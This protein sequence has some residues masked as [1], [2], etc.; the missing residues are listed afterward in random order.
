MQEKKRQ[1]NNQTSSVVQSL[2]CGVEMGK[3]EVLSA[4]CWLRG[5][6]WILT[7]ARVENA[8]GRKSLSY[9]PVISPFFLLWQVHVHVCKCTCVHMHVED[10]GQPQLEFLR[11]ECCPPCLMGQGFSPVWNF[12]SRLGWVANVPP[13]IFLS[14]PFHFGDYK[15]MPPHLAF[16]V[17][18]EEQTQV[19]TRLQPKLNW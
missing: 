12:P 3:A 2:H 8:R 15:C 6:Y 19:S 17:G 11:N 1:P 9:A 7:L 14:P 13:G 5:A 18:A 4:W 10:R 16:H